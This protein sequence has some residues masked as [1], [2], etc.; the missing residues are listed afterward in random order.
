MLHYEETAV[1][2]HRTTGKRKRKLS[3]R[4]RIKLTA[5]ELEALMLAYQDAVTQMKHEA[6]AEKYSAREDLLMEHAA[7][8]RDKLQVMNDRC[9]KGYTLSLTNIEAMAVYELWQR[10]FG[11]NTYSRIVVQ[12]VLDEFDSLKTH[13]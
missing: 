6:K 8:L 12:K 3:P 13:Q 2:K 7:S 4:M 5:N 9:Q 11:I 10:S 1:K